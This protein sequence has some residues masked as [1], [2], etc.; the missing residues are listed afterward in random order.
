MIQS[1]FQ[2]DVITNQLRFI[3]YTYQIEDKHVDIHWLLGGT[4]RF[5]RFGQS[6]DNPCDTIN[7]FVNNP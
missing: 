2:A 1:G 7:F 6:V 5:R 3:G 4:L